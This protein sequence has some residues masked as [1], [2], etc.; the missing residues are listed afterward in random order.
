MYRSKCHRGCQ[1]LLP[2]HGKMEEGYQGD[3]H[4]RSVPVTLGQVELKRGNIYS[5]D[6]VPKNL[7]EAQIRLHTYLSFNKWKSVPR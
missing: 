3:K 6:R 2:Q 1:G 4:R 7:F 5:P